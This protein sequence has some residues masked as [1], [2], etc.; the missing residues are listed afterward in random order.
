MRVERIFPN[1]AAY[2]RLIRALAGPDPRSV[3]LGTH[4]PQ[5]SHRPR[6]S[7]KATTSGSQGGGTNVDR[8]RVVVSHLQMGQRE[9]HIIKLQKILDTTEPG[10]WG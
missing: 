9:S 2:L 3:G 10:V 4:L 8:T 6:T 1:E 5:R 7:G